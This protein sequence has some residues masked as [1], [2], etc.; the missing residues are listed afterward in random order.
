MKGHGFI[1]TRV[2]GLSSVSRRWIDSKECLRG[3]PPWVPP[4][5]MREQLLELLRL[6]ESG[7]LGKKHFIANMVLEASEDGSGHW[8]LVRQAYGLDWLTWRFSTA[9]KWRWEHMNLVEALL[10]HLTQ[11]CQQDVFDANGTFVSRQ[12]RMALDPNFILDHAKSSLKTLE[13]V[14]QEVPV[15]HLEEGRWCYRPKVFKWQCFLVAWLI[16]KEKCLKKGLA[17][18]NP[19]PV[20]KQGNIVMVC[21]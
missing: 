17:L 11:W 8:L 15:V 16:R 20:D 3:R 19:Q 18:P 6:F 5:V 2:A 9:G 21:L 7:E 13:V 12:E 4:E 10:G 1:N 14:L